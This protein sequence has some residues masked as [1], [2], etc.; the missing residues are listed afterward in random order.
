MPFHHRYRRM[1]GRLKRVGIANH[2]VSKINDTINPIVSPMHKD[3]NVN[4]LRE[5]SLTRGET[6]KL[7]NMKIGSTIDNKTNNKLKETSKK[8][9]KFIQFSI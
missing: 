9:S 2:I 8:L 6:L 3:D 5:S 7:E 1:G 4:S